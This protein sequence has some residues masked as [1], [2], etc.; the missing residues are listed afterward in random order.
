MEI[1]IEGLEV[2]AHHGV[3]REE[4]AVGGRYVVDVSLFLEHCRAMHTDD[5]ED[6]VDYGAV[7]TLIV[8]TVVRHQFQLLER[9][10]AAVG[11][12][13]LAAFPVDRVRVRV[14]KPAPPLTAVVAVAA[15][16]IELA[17]TSS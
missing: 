17:R 13:I 8:N 16:T 1:T 5:L 2:F 15:A 11:E 14:A 10:A 4:R 9:L 12:A 7:S 3:T 6:T